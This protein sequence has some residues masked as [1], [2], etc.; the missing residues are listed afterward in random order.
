MRTTLNLDPEVYRQAAKATGVE[1]KTK[2]IHLGLKALIQESAR[3]RLA[4]LYGRIRKASAP[5]RRRWE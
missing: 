1:E 3:K 2:L 5:S 4:S